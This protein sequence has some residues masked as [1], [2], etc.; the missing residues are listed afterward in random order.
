MKLVSLISVRVLIVCCE[1]FVL[2]MLCCCRLNVVFLVICRCGKSEYDW[3]I[4]LM[5]CLFVGI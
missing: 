4:M 2:L 1:V 5:L 3:K